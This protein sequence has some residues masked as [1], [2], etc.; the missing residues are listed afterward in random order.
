M[1]SCQNP[2]LARRRLKTLRSIMAL[3]LREIA[4]TYGRSRGGYLWAILQPTGTIAVMTVVFSAAFRSPA[5]GTNFPMFYATGF[6][7]FALY[8]DASNKVTQSLM[9][10]RQLLQYPTVSFV[11]AI[12]ARFLLSLLTRLMVF[13]LVMSGI[14]F[15]FDL[16]LILDFPAIL[17][18]LAMAA[19]LG[20]GVGCMNCFLKSMYPIWEQIW[21]VLTAPMFI[22]ST[23]FFTLEVVPPQY[24]TYLWFNPLVH[25]VAMMRRGFYPMYDAAYVS[26]PYVFGVSLTLI[27]LA[28]AFLKHWHRYILNL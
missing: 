22:I 8:L 5:L 9:F 4:T 14:V 23:I 17:I 26:T 15:V 1:F 24:R 10:S 13:Y 2:P 25:I 19:T 16:P 11:D 6:L 28:L 3:I 27:A 7:P 18:S 21:N 12:V 20:L